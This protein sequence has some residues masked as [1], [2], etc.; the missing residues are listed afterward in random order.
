[1]G[2][3]RNSESAFGILLII[4]SLIALAFVFL[5]VRRTVAANAAAG[6]AGVAAPAAPAVGAVGAV[7]AAAAARRTTC[8]F[9][10][11]PTRLV[12]FLTQQHTFVK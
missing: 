3:E 5:F 6:A 4:L 11:P 1:M 9:V 2:D 7:G 10:I 8:V 12:P